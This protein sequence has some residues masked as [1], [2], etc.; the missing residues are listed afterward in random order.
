[1]KLSIVS[2]H[3]CCLLVDEHIFLLALCG[4][5]Q[6]CKNRPAPFLARSHKKHAKPGLF[7]LLTRTLGLFVFCISGASSALFL[8]CWMVSTCT[9]DCLKRLVSEMT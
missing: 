1:M 5:L 4:R 7:V 6:D 8:R 3:N 2:T 9:I